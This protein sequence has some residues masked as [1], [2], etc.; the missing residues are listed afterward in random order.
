MLTTCA[1][2]SQQVAFKIAL[3]DLLRQKYGQFVHESV[4]SC[5]CVCVC[6]CVCLQDHTPSIYRETEDTKSFS[7]FIPL[8]LFLMQKKETS[9]PTKLCIIT[10]LNSLCSVYIT[11]VAT[12]D[13][14]GYSEQQ[15]ADSLPGQ[16]Q[17]EHITSAIV[18]HV[19]SPDNPLTTVMQGLKVIL[20]VVQYNVG[21]IQLFRYGLRD[22]PVYI[23]KANLFCCQD[24]SG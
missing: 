21:Q 8:L 14:M 16:S 12:G 24:I 20:S 18:G 2:L 23:L 9:V 1:V 10:I 6:V 17:L 15:Q 19:T 13:E 7:R 11:F 3:L 4:C 22:K 5:V